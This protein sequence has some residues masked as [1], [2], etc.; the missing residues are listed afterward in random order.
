MWP[1]LP[2]LEGDLPAL[3]HVFPEVL[4]ETGGE[5]GSRTAMFTS[6][7]MPNERLSK[8]VDPTTDHRPSMIRIFAWIIDGLIFVDLPAGFEHVTV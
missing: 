7:L 6:S 5:L 2:L 8:F 3:L 1:V 4:R